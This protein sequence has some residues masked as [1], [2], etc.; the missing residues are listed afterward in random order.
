MKE[1]KKFVAEL[2]GTGVLV[3]VGVGSAVLAGSEVGYLG[4]ALAFGLTLLAMVYAIG[5]V[6]GCHINPAVT[7]AMLAQGG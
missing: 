6:S 4:I 3:F 1:M 7:I 2:I 5:S